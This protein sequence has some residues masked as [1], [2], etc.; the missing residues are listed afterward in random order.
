V[1]ETLTPGDGQDA[2]ASIKLAWERRDPDAIMERFSDDAEY[3]TD[4]FEPPLVGANAIRE[5]WNEVAA[6]HV[7]VEFDAERVWVSGRTILASW[8]AA[9]T[10]RASGDRVRVRGFS[11]LELDDD[12]R[13][14]R[15]RDW[16]LTREV[17]RDA[18]YAP[19]ATP[20]QPGEGQD[21]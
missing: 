5:H 15:M 3:R 12:G 2:L 10:R 19:E 11:T 17:G 4:P 20:Q 7:H 1:P 9:Y 13:I 18:R 8:H 14:A 6:T 16:S 21:G